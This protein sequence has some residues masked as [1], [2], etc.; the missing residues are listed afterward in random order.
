MPFV[1]I[2]KEILCSKERREAQARSALTHENQLGYYGC[3]FL[4][5]NYKK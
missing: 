2:T 5:L 4:Q 1:V 3:F